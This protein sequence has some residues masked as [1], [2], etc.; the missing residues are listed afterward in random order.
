MRHFNGHTYDW[1]APQNA[2]TSGF[3]PEAIAKRIGARAV[4]S[5][6]SQY[7]QNANQRYAY[8]VLLSLAFRPEA[9]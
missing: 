1:T 3:V 7:S 5:Q 9:S 8:K 2:T 4:S 6:Y